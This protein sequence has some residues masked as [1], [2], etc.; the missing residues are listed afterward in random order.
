MEMTIDSAA[1]IGHLLCARNWANCL[2]PCP[3][4]PVKM[5]HG[6]ANSPA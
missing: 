6:K 4:N 2:S 5:R 3:N 1:H